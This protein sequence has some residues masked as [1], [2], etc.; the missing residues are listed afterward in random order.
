MPRDFCKRKTVTTISIIFFHEIFLLLLVYISLSI[1]WFIAINWLTAARSND[2]YILITRISLLF[3]LKQ[4]Y[5][6]WTKQFF[7]EDSIWARLGGV[8]CLVAY[9]IVKLQNDSKKLNESYKDSLK[10]NEENKNG[11]FPHLPVIYE[12]QEREIIISTS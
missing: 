3:R 8:G 9:W 2:V 11:N 4:L 1:C 7:N 6:K 12:H 10:L 5:K